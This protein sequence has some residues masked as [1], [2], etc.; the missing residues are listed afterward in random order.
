[1]YI[2]IHADKFAS[3]VRVNDTSDTSDM[4]E[5]GVDQLNRFPP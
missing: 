2:S 3:T 4:M 5:R 1:M